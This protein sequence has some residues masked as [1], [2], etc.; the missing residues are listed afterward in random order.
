MGFY[1]KYSNVLYPMTVPQA[2]AVSKTRMAQIPPP[3]NPK[4]IFVIVPPAP[5]A[6]LRTNAI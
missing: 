4:Q 3:T 1:K 6:A 2:S 5:G